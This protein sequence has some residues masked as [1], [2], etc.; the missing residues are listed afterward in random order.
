MTIAPAVEPLARFDACNPFAIDAAI[1]TA[2]EY[3]AG[4]VPATWRR[5]PDTGDYLVTTTDDAPRRADA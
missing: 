3:S 2:A 4:G 5:D 1:W